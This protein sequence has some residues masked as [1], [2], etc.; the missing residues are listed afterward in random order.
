MPEFDV[1]AIVMDVDQNKLL[2][3]IVIVDKT[4]TFIWVCSDPGSCIDSKVVSM[5]EGIHCSEFP[6]LSTEP[7]QSFDLSLL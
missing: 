1:L 6:G 5:S 7:N 2:K 3:D 4:Y